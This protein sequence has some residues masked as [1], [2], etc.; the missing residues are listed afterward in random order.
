MSQP[1]HLSLLLLVAFVPMLLESRRSTAHYRALV[2]AG[3][4]EPADD[5]FAVMQI[6][7]PASFL[8][9]IAEAWFRGLPSGS[10]IFAGALVFAAAKAI[11]CW[12]IATLGSRWTFRVVVPPRSSL[13]SGGPYRYLRH[14]NYVGVM[15]ELIGFGLLAGAVLTGTAATL[16]FA[17]ILLARVRVEERALGLRSR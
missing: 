17:A 14:P 12:A 4:L 3:A 16:I 10:V 1:L 8:A 7:Y 2:A 15:G 9:M 11:K 5:V 6:A 13:V